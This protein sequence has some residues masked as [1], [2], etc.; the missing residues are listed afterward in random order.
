MNFKGQG[1]IKKTCYPG[2]CLKRMTKSRIMGSEDSD[3]AQIGTGKVIHTRSATV[4]TN[5]LGLTDSCM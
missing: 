5:S 4:L 2:I 1:Q 3:P